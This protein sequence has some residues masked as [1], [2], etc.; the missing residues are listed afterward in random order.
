VPKF[1]KED[2]AGPGFRRRPVLHT[3]QP[4]MIFSF[5]I[6]SELVL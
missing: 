5:R 4:F 2:T 6:Q 3:Q 1:K